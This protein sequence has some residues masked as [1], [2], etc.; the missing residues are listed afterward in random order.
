MNPFDP[1][2]YEGP[3]KEYPSR[4]DIENLMSIL[5]KACGSWAMETDTPA[6]A[7]L[8]LAKFYFSARGQNDP[9]PHQRYFQNLTS[10]TLRAAV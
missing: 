4:E 6:L 9:K 10:E 7:E 5:D 8:L 2:L 1:K 3:D